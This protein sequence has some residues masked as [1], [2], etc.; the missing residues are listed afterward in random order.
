[1]RMAP[2]VAVELRGSRAWDAA[3]ALLGAL[4]SVAVAAALAAHLQ[5]G[6]VASGLSIACAAGAGALLSWL[7]RPR[8][9]GR[10]RWDGARWWYRADQGAAAEHTGRLI[11]AIDF[12]TWML[13]RFDAAP[14]MRPRRVWLPVGDRGL[15]QAAALRTAAYG[16]RPTPEPAP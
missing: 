14:G 6:A 1:M 12:G 13:L 3:C 5:A 7:A 10:L 2:A 9:C 8:G 4:A 16:A 15:V 11:V